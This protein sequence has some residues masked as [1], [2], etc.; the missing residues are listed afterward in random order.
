MFLWAIAGT[1]T[2]A[3]VEALCNIRSWPKAIAWSMFYVLAGLPLL[4]VAGFAHLAVAIHSARR[5]ACGASALVA[6]GLY[7]TFVPFSIGAL[8]VGLCAVGCGILC[9]GLSSLVA[10]VLD[11]EERAKTLRAFLA[12]P[13]DSYAPRFLA[14]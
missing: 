14:S 12:R 8:P 3:L 9:A 11:G 7:L 5:V 10:I 2:W 6:G 13:I 1:M 4:M